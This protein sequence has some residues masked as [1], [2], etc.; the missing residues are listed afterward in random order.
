MI[1]EYTELQDAN[2]LA[3]LNPT[4]SKTA[5]NG[6]VGEDGA[7]FDMD[8][9]MDDVPNGA[10][11]DGSDEMD[12]SDDVQD[13]LARSDQLQQQAIAYGQ[14]L[15]AEFKDDPRREVKKALEDTFSL[16]AYEDARKSKMAW[17]MHTDG[18][19]TVAEELNG[20]IL[21]SLGK[22]SAAALERIIQQSVVFGELLAEDGG[23]GAFINVRGD[24]LK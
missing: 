7:T 23:V 13:G 15:Q 20:A 14:E 21:V 9:D 6:H 18:R 8:L 2:Q 22:S 10:K 16:I 24:Y 3:E 17:L 19:A 5:L 4:R 1:R 11:M 12:T